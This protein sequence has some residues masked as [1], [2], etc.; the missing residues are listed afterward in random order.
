MRTFATRHAV[1]SYYVLT[2]A[3]S[4]GSVLAIVGG[5]A[6]LPGTASD[7]AR[8]MPV[9]I[10]AMLL[11]PFI[12]AIAITGL[13]DG[14]AGFRALGSHLLAWRAEPIWYAIALLTAPCVFLLALLVLSLTSPVFVPAVFGADDKLAF[15][16][17]A[18]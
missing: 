11:G 5:P 3:I 10:P 6:G 9:V 15:I 14:S 2:F 7:I 17:V 13:A 18:T 4:W 16:L 12:A 1:L 8:L